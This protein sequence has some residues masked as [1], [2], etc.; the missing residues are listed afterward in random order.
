LFLGEKSLSIF[1]YDGVR[2]VINVLIVIISDTS[3]RKSQKQDRNLQLVTAEN[4][5]WKESWSDSQHSLDQL[6]FRRN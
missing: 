6:P 3:K 4:K 5:I 2:A 1:Y